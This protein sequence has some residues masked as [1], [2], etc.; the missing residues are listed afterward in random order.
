MIRFCTYD[1]VLADASFQSPVKTFSIPAD[2]RRMV[3][4]MCERV[5]TSTVPSQDGYIRLKDKDEV[6]NNI[7]K[8]STG[9]K[10]TA[11]KPN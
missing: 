8:P 2:Y 9:Y 10:I 11:Y 5:M 6:Y 3:M 4:M 7:D 1:H